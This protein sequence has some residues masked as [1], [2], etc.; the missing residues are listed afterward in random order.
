MNKFEI[1][2]TVVSWGTTKGQDWV[3][4]SVME[5]P[6]CVYLADNDLRDLEKK[7]ALGGAYIQATGYLKSNQYTDNV[8]VVATSLEVME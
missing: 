2:G 4:V 7:Y 1:R 8:A 6:I 3:E 5:G